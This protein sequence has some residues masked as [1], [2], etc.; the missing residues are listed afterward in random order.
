MSE[1][2][3]AGPTIPCFSEMFRFADDSD[4]TQHARE[5][6][7]EAFAYGINL[8]LRIFPGAIPPSKKAKLALG[9]ALPPKRA[10]EIIYRSDYRST[11]YGNRL[12]SCTTPELA[13]QRCSNQSGA[14]PFE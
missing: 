2:E 8:D 10:Q 12:L 14:R 4:V 13:A 5:L 7:A 1:N 9:I 6:R 11:G 3:N